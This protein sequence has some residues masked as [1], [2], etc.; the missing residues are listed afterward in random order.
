MRQ[1]WSYVFLA[2]THWHVQKFEDNADFTVVSLLQ[3]GSGE[4]EN[5]II[6][7]LQVNIISEIGHWS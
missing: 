4:S 1:Q 6:F 2:L 3:S 7:E 5:P